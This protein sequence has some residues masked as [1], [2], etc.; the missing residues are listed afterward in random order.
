MSPSW[1]NG[2]SEPSPPALTQR[3]LGCKNG[4]IR[5]VAYCGSLL[6]WAHGTVSVREHL[7]GFIRFI[8]LHVESMRLN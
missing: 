3:R 4:A 1:E 2:T 7:T 5:L 8:S 6:L